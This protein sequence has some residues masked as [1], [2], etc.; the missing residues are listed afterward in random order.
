MNTSAGFRN[1][2]N[3][4]PLL[5]SAVCTGCGRCVEAC[6]SEVL[7]IAQGR[8]RLIHP[9]LCSYCGDC[10]EACSNHGIALVFEVVFSHRAEVTS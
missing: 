7:G 6:A 8:S 9:E 3:P 2:E 4:L 5:D 1:E 10:E